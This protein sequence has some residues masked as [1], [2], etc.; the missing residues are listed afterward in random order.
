MG[1]VRFNPS[2]ND[3]DGLKDSDTTFSEDDQS[4]METQGSANLKHASQDTSNKPAPTNVLQSTTFKLP[5]FM[6][7]VRSV[8]QHEEDLVMDFLHELSKEER[9]SLDKELREEEKIE[10]HDEELDEGYEK[11]LWKSFGLLE[12]DSEKGS[13]EEPPPKDMTTSVR[14]KI[15]SKPIIPSSEEEAKSSEEESQ[16]DISLRLDSE[17][18]AESEKVEDGLNS[19]ERDE[20]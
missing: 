18:D 7:N 13:D 12:E 14:K 9:R 3:K 4:A 1:D 6:P 2:L 17:E 8:S 19:S 15:K 10:Y 20:V 11:N 16:S 5:P